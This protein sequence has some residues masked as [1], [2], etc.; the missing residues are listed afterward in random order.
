VT[1]VPGALVHGYVRVIDTS[2]GQT[3]HTTTVKGSP[4]EATLDWNQQGVPGAPGARGRAGRSAT[5]SGANLVT[6]SGGGVVTVAADHGLPNNTP[7]I[8]PS[9]NPVGTIS[10]TDGTSHIKFQVF[11]ASFAKTRSSATGGAPSVHELVLTKILDQA[12][13]TLARACANG[14]HFPRAVLTV[15]KAGAG[16]PIYVLTGGVSVSSFSMSS[17]GD[18][19]TESLTFNFTK[20]S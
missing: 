8:R 10:I 18:R 19:P 1:S 9:A 4:L 6:I 17:G 14:K 5:I 3:C 16:D 20:L 13:P 7:T 2:A 11:S 12:S 15:R